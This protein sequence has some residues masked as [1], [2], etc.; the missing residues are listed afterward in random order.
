MN[1]TN[2]AAASRFSGGLPEFLDAL[3]RLYRCFGLE[4]DAAQAATFADAEIFA[5]APLEQ[6]L[7]A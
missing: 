7:V 1:A 3:E 4:P 6:E 5:P 2:T